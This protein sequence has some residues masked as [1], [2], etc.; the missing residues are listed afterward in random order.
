M[1][2]QEL[3]L[4]AYDKS[5]IS[6][7]T[8]NFYRYPARFSPTFAA[9]AIQL[10]SNPGDF[11]LDPFMGGGTSVV[12]S[13]IHGRNVIGT[14]LNSLA[15]FIARAKTTTLNPAEEDMI[16][17]WLD[18]TI[19]QLSF[20]GFL[21]QTL[22]V[23]KTKNLSIPRARF[24]KKIIAQIKYHIQEIVDSRVKRFIKCA[25]LK[26]AQWALDGRRTQVNV[27]QFCETFQQNVLEMLE[28]IIEFGT[29]LEN[30]IHR[31]TNRYLKQIDA[32]QIHTL[33]IFSKKKLKVDLVVTSPPY[34]GLHVL[35]HRWQVDGRKET[36]APYW[37]AECQDGQ[38][39]AYYNFGSR[40]QKRYQSYFDKCLEALQ[41][42]RSVMRQGAYIVQLVAF[43]EPEINF[44]RYL[45]IM[46]IA[47]Y[48]EINYDHSDRIWRTVPNRRWH[49]SLQRGTQP[50]K[51]VV[52]I[53]RTI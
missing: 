25:L 29:I 7:L 4:A 40:H 10:F 26:T 36:P 13:M 12:E 35:Y 44:P 24:V 53:H 43:R 39:A 38:G 6:G 1:N 23:E 14:D 20:H 33:P 31:E 27:R 15:V 21:R 49:A 30:Q 9:T 17:S 51:E 46:H 16:R 37:I 45:E 28:Q 41:N 48:E 18:K 5:R 8:H 52:L 2:I 32:C 47:G 22:D 19:P 3:E 50:S 42:I 34:P 11:I